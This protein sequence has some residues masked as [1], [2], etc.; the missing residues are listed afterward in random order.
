MSNE[1]IAELTKRM[2]EPVRVRPYEEV[3]KTLDK[4]VNDTAY[5]GAIEFAKLFKTGEQA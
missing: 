2:E 1:K 3:K 5:S 4:L